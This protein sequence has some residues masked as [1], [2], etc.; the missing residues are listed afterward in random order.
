MLKI[1]YAGTP[2]FAVPALEALL[3]SNHQLVAV[4]TQPDRPAGRGRKLQPGPV[5]VCALQHDIPVLQP[6]NFKQQQDI[7]EFKA[8][9]A[10][11]MVVAAY[12]ILLPAVILNAPRLG[13]VNLHASL[14]PRW[15]GA[16]PIQRAILA[17]DVETGIT[18]MQ[19]DAGLDS[20]NMLATSRVNILPQT[21]AEALH[22]QLSYSGAHLLMAKLS[23]IEDQSIPSMA[24]D[25]AAVTYASKLTKQE[26]LIDWSQPAQQIQRAIRAY[27]P[28][29]VSFSYLQG[30]SVK[31]WS[32]QFSHQPCTAAAGQIIAHTPEGIQVCC[33]EGV[34][35]VTEMQFAGKK[36]A[37]AG[38]ILNGRNLLD[39]VFADA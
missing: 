3:Q 22:D 14:L 9:A 36:R 23:A 15:R 38:Q 35:T 2:E 10:D 18:L 13:C 39:A 6:E 16:A 4:Y 25:P 11:L 27:N 31:L 29:P 30:Q 1:I 20:G 37:T 34:L 5:K 19:M 24:Q 17:G 26:A 12:G 32:A 28:W 7:G 21:T 8:F 33:G